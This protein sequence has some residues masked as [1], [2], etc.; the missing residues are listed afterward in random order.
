MVYW[1]HEEGGSLCTAHDDGG[2]IT[3]YGAEMYAVDWSTNLPA[4]KEFING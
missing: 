1:E 3:K 2:I 4:L